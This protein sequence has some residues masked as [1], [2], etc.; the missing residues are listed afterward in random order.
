MSKKI[1]I[2]G[3][4][5]SIGSQTLQVVDMFP[6]DFEVVA[7]AAGSNVQLLAEQVVKYKPRLVA[8]MDETKLA[9]FKRAVAGLDVEVVVGSDGLNAVATMAEVNYVVSAVSGRIGLVPTL[10]AIRAGKDIGLANK[11][12]LVAAGALVMEAARAYGV[13][14]LPID[15]EHSAIFQCLERERQAVERLILTAS[16]GPFLGYT[17]AQL[18]NVTKTAAL[19][20]P[21]WS[22]GAKITIDSAT[23]MNKGLEVIEAHWLFDMAWDKIC[24]IVHPQSI[25]HSMV[26]YA[27]GSILAHLGQPDMRIPIQYALTYPQ[28]RANPL[29]K[30]DLVGKTLTFMEP[31]RETFPAL[32]LAESAG[33]RGGTMPAVMNAANEAAVELLLQDRITFT[34]ITKVVELVMA[35]HQVINQ[36]DLSQILDSDAWAREEVLH[37]AATI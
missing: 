20:H 5:G 6:A 21:N 16:G 37:T 2:L 24:V 8:V 30:L 29:T 13:S 11:E 22:M 19:H 10:A 31:D 35:R 4:T 15:S 23:L 9:E 1:A 7:L 18:Q 27:D 12:T 36:P 33:R 25:I 26:E 32:Q 3:A 28:R 14:V 34:A 17:R